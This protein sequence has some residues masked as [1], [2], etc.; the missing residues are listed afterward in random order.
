MVIISFPSY[1]LEISKIES[2]NNFYE[3]LKI[4][5]GEKFDNF[6]WIILKELFE[7]FLL[8]DIV[9]D[10]RINTLSIEILID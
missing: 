2:L 5:T 10:F 9:T 4:K 7:R 6:T 1:I 3:Y 8:F